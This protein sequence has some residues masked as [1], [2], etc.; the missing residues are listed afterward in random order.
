MDPKSIEQIFWD[1]GRIASPDEQDAYLDR[2]C[3]GDAELRRRVEELLQARSKASNFLE[4]VVPTPV[5]TVEEL[6][7]ERPGT[8]I[9]AYKLLEQ[10]GEGGFGVVFMAEQQQPLRRKVALKVL[11]PG[12]DTRQVVA[13]FEAER[14]ALALMDHHNIAHILDGGETV[15]GRPYF[16]MELVKG[17]P[18]THFCDEGHL[19]IRQRLELFAP[20]CQAVQHAHQ[21]GIIHRDLKPSNILVTLH[22]DRPVVKVIDFGIAKATGQ[23]L[24]DKTLFTGFAQLIGTPLYMSP[25]QAGMSGLD[26]D[27]RSDIYALGVLLYELLTGTTPF[28]KERLR[29]V[30]YDELRRIIREEEPARPSTRM[31]TLGQAAA[32]ASDNRKSD[33]RRLSQLFRG[34]LDWIVMRALEKDR[35]RRYDTA[36]AFAADVQRYLD[37][38][39]VLACPPSAWYRFRKFARRNKAVL[40]TAATVALVVLMAVGSIGWVIRDRSTRQARLN[41][42]IEIA[43]QEASSARDRALTL[44][45]DRYQWEAALAAASSALKRAEELASQDETSLE[46]AVQDRL[47]A[48]RASLDAD[49]RD[50]RFIA[51]FDELLLGVVVWDARRSRSKSA[52]AFAH[53]REALQTTYGIGWGQTPPADVASMIQQRPKPIQEN[54]LAAFD[55]CLTRELNE[56][57]PAQ[58]WLAA[59]LATAD[60][61]PWR[62]QARQALAAQD[63]R[64]LERLVKQEAAVRQRPAFLHLLLSQLPDEYLATKADLQWQ[65]QQ[66][67]PGEFWVHNRFAIALAFDNLA[68]LLANAPDPSYRDA[69]RALRLSKEAVRLAPNDGDFRNTLGVAHYRVGN[70]KE[71]IV[72]LQQAVELSKGGNVGDWYF[73]AMAHWQLGNQEEARKCYNQAIQKNRRAD[74]EELQRFRIEASTLLGIDK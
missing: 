72:A 46:P 57:R 64:T 3:G 5:A 10:I 58:R 53:I 27:T 56:D 44:T 32:T 26:I 19:S 8:V 34:E 43:L 63:W 40:V 70:W 66:A 37:D 42:G 2:A 6:I 28:D 24:T 11:K 9:G 52:E 61:D 12:M 4:S 21:K 33:P 39:A 47:K 73:L 30:G 23:Q 38:E 29:K 54:L 68:W 22:D 74:T 1:A 55:V 18:M 7:G 45:D 65:I 16:V 67:H 13:R 48:L 50:R 36:S 71:A 31:S 35:N 20:V 59:V 62:K 49:E 17:I 69:K 60:S 14:Q 51:Q 15:S 41:Y 25:E